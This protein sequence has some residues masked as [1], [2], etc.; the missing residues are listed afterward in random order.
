M[1]KKFGWLPVVSVQIIDEIAKIR[2]CV[3][4]RRLRKLPIK[5]FFEEC[6]QM[7][8]SFNKKIKIKELIH[9]IC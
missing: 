3:K 9:N 1:L 6:Y 2:I 7:F 5:T 8:E 4:L